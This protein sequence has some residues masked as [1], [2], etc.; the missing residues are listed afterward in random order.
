M[1]IKASNFPTVRPTLDLNFAATKRLDP[2]VTFSRAS[3][4]TYV[5]GNGVLQSAAANVPRFDHNPAT[6]E[7]LGLLVE[8]ARTNVVTYS[9]I[10]NTSWAV[11]DGATIA[12]NTAIAPDGTPTAAL[13]T[14]PGT[15][16]PRINRSL[17]IGAGTV[18]QTVW[19]RAVSGTVTI[20]VGNPSD[21][22][23]N[24][25]IGTAWTRVQ[26]SYASGSNSFG[27]YCSNPVAAAQFYAWGAQLEAGT[28][29]T[30]YIPTPA[31]FTGRAST[32]T[33]YDAN[34]IIQTAASGVARSNA[35]FPDSSGVMR[36]AGLLLEEA[37]TNVVTYSVI[38][39]TNWT[40]TDGATITANAAV[41][42]DGTLTAALV[43]FPGTGAP[44]INRSLTVGA[45]TVTQTVWIKAVTGTVS[46]RVG[47]PSDFGANQT[48]G[49]TWTRVSASYASGSNSFGIYCSN[50]VSAASFHVWGA[51]MELGS[52]PTSYIPTTGSTVTRAAD[53]ST[54][55]TVTRSADVAQITGANFSS[56]Y[57]QDEGS[58]YFSGN[59]RE[60]GTSNYVN[61]AL[62][63]TGLTINIP[64]IG[65]NVSSTGSQLYGVFSNGA[66]ISGI[67]PATPTNLKLAVGVRVNDAGFSRDGGSAVTSSSVSVRSDADRLLIGAAGASGS[68]AQP[69]GTISRLTYWP[70]RLSDATLQTITK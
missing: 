39:A 48:I 31:T 64:S 50:P 52:Y 43:T 8:E 25:T 23:F 59:A 42:P 18:T 21:F 68:P 56:W 34:G 3:T 12:P 22:G 9:V 20:R 49:T 19:I 45:G 27:I 67:L 1:T 6:G 16:A 62:V 60:D 32:A 5:D 66:L 24:Q 4:G 10:D 55:A 13:V 11:T 65:F 63:T 7:S 36:P 14:F 15:G 30:S 61:L 35:Y 57:R 51:Q 44:R 58:L 37:R 54:S 29:P 17:T 69:N 40:T 53:T 2:R 47:N 38:D 28:F 26:A 33:Y 46:I 41:A 70:T